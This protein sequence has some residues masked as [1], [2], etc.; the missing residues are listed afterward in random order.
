VTKVRLW[1]HQTF[2]SFAY[3]NFR[4]FFTGMAI[5]MTGT[6]VQQVAQVWLVLDLGGNGV[7]LG[8][9]TALQFAPVLLFGA[10]AGVLADRF[11]KRRI[12]FVTQTLALLFALALGVLALSGGATLTSVWALAFALGCVTAADNPARR[13]F[14]TDLVPTDDIPNAVG[15]NSAVMTASRIVGPAIAGVLISQAGVGWCFVANSVSF[16]AVLAAL[17]AMRSSEFRASPIVPRQKGQVRAGLRYVWS[18]PSLRLPLLLT[19]VIGTIAFNYPVVLPLLAKET[20]SGDAGTYTLLFSLMGVGS[21][22]GALAAASRSRSGP[23]FMVAAAAA[24]GLTTI[25]AAV[26]PTLPL[27]VVALVPVGLT[28]IAFMSS[29]TAELQL[30][31]DPTMRGRVLA[32]HA[33]VF[34]GST[35]VGGPLVGWITEA[36]GP[37]VGLAIGGVGALVAVAVAV[38]ARRAHPLS[39]LADGWHARRDLHRLAA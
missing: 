5:S 13:A 4:L 35:P 31:S 15:L 2:R 24:F 32:L 25:V 37:R 28:G 10:W 22:V 23:R 27:A 8:I 39:D 7:E 17:A 36:F 9:T 3:R 20:F 1:S 30:N 6:W 11:E 18:T 14:V 29:A 16:L 26:A 38:R 12:L 21:L 33:V 19:A 34:L